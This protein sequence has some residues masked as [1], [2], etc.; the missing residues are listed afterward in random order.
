MAE[1]I[2]L[3]PPPQQNVRYATLGWEIHSLK[4][5]TTMTSHTHFPQTVQVYIVNDKQ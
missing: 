3:P 5:T 2:L 4:V 1:R